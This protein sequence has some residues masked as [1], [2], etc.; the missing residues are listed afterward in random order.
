MDCV[1]E[2]LIFV[3][4]DVS[5]RDIEEDAVNG[6]RG[7]C[8]VSKRCIEEDTVNGSRGRCNACCTS[9]GEESK[10]EDEHLLSFW[11]FFGFFIFLI[12]VYLG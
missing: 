11:I 5:K 10:E 2:E 7:R 12:F 6:S 8:D 4:G 3:D 9:N 1:E